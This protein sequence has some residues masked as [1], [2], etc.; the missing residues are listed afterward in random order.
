MQGA[1]SG[2]Y[3]LFSERE[4]VYVGEGWNCLLRV[5]EHTRTD[6]TKAFLSWNFIPIDDK[7]ERKTLERELRRQHRPRDNKI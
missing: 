4:L 2:V 1:R 6:S 7:Q 3:F 5:A